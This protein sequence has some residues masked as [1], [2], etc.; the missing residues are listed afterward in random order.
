MTDEE[1]EADG[2]VV[3]HYPA[4]GGEPY[5][6]GPYPPDERE[7]I[8]QFVAEQECTCRRVLFP[9]GFPRGIKMLMVLDV[10]AAL[11]TTTPRRT[12]PVH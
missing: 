10:E 2:W 9:L 4:D 11:L 3:V 1:H 5:A 7:S 12:E 8:E 6:L